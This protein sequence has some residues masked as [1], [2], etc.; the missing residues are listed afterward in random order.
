L[1]GYTVAS[2]VSYSAIAQYLRCPLQYYFQRV[3]RLPIDRVVS[4]LVFGGA[5]HAALANFHR[6]LQQIESAGGGVVHREAVYQALLDEY[7]EREQQTRVVYSSGESRLGLIDEAMALVEMYLAAE[8]PAKILNVEQWVSAPLIT[9]TRQ[10]LATPLAAVADLVYGDVRQ[11]I[12]R[13]LKTSRTPY[14]YADVDTALQG[15]CYAHAVEQTIGIRPRVEYAVLL[16]TQAPQLQ[17]L[18]T[19]RRPEQ[20]TRLADLVATVQ[21]AV[22]ADVFYPIESSFNCS[23]CPFRSECR[24]WRPVSPQERALVRQLNEIPIEQVLD[25]VTIATNTHPLRQQEVVRC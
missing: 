9:S 21:K 11:P 13:E 2:H 7:T 3:L 4:G 15:T 8:P 6:Q 17:T 22:A 16:R 5:V 23:G 25:R 18:F 20:M 24:D 12:V 19:T 10:V 14:R 1:E